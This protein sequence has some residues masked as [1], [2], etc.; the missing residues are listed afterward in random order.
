MKRWL[1]WGIGLALLSGLV[2]LPALTWGFS[3][4][5]G[6]PD[7]AVITDYRADFVVS[8]D[9]RLAATETLQVALPAGKHG[10]FRFFDL[11][12]PGDSKVRLIPRDLSVTRDGQA[13]DFE[14]LK[15]GRGRYRNVKIGS[16]Y[17]TLSG[18]HTYVIRYRIDGALAP[19][20][21]H[22]DATQFYWNLIPGGWRTAI[23]Q[24]RLTVT[25]P[26]DTHDVRCA[27][28]VKAT[29]GCE[30]QGLGSRT[31]EVRTGA[32]AR[33]TPVTLKT[34]LDMPTPD[35]PH[36]AWPIRFDPVFGTSLIGLVALLMLAG[37]GAVLGL[38]LG[39]TS[40]EPKPQFPLMYAPPDGIGPAQGK[41]LFT[42]RVGREAFVASLM[43][44]AEKG[45]TTLDH[46]SDWTISDTGQAAAWQSLDP[47]SGFAAQSLGVTGGRFTVGTSPAAGKVLK[48]ALSSFDEAT[49][50]WARQNGL[51]VKAGLGSFGGLL[52]ILAI[53]LTLFL[54]LVNPF[55]VSV[56][57]LAPGLF[58]LFAIE[59]LA[60]GA[61][62]K[63][64]PAGRELWSRIGGFRRMLATPSAEQR[65]DFSGRKELYTAYIPWAV[66]FGVAD[67]WAAKY[68]LETGEDPPSPSYFGAG[69]AGYTGGGFASA[70]A[71][72]FSASVDSAIS[73]YEATQTS[74][75][76]SGG[77]GFSGGGGGGGG[78]GGSW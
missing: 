74:S 21:G 42:E 17:R 36:R 4:G 32:L 43:Q 72:D 27:V 77:G 31:L 3:G 12:D 60:P 73:S 22:G 20:R 78:G 18:Q 9:G 13:E 11:A 33:N 75:S 30:A 63:R 1:G 2:L 65:F 16:A 54:A 50:S 44:T 47:V 49:R 58:A 5:S 39:V 25:L 29:S 64:T 15:E 66:A 26:A 28:G 70:M 8:E 34:T 56:L 38:R 59:L 19:A 55:G 71:D 10:I 62:T 35:R 45:A 6:E 51:M 41:Y 48:D 76:S 69:A 53:G 7:T 61:S 68:R 37:V 14:V 23:Q 57:A 24:S 40:R 46:T 67:Q 52:V